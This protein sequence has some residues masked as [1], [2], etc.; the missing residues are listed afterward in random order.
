MQTPDDWQALGAA[1]GVVGGVATAIASA[2]WAFRKV[3]RNDRVADAQAAG[4][5]GSFDQLY[6]LLDDKDGTIKDLRDALK[7][8]NQRA[9][10]AFK[11]RNEAVKEQGAQQVRVETLTDQVRL[12]Q[13]RVRA[14]EAQIA[15]LMD[16]L[17]HA[18][19]S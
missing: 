1:G 14:L 10:D 9:D 8:A 5:V 18:Q 13:D 6:K 16:V 3:W 7:T 11:E 2:V 17:K 12:L 4:A 15:Q 19:H